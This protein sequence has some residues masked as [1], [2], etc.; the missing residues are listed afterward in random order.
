[1]NA[2]AVGKLGGEEVVL[3]AGDDGMVRI[4]GADGRPRGEPLEGH[5]AS[6]NAVALGVLR[7]EEVVLS[8]GD[9]GTVRI[10]GADG[11]PRGEPLEG[12][13]A[14]VNAVELGVFG[15]EEVVVSGGDDGTVRI[16][17]ADRESL[18]ISVGASVSGLALCSSSSIVACGK[19]GLAYFAIA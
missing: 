13:G 3:S 18:A 4:W 2:V 11:R 14:S 17:S 16:W 1:V 9:D 5:G 12:H 7:G 10:W 6:V 8:A 19:F 15:G